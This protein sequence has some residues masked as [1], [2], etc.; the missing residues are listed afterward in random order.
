[1]AAPLP[2]V[3]FKI[4]LQGYLRYWERFY[5]PYEWKRGSILL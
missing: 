1:M 5:L 2:T 3:D 4:P